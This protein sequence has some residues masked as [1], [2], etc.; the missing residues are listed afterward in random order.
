MTREAVVLCFLA[1]ANSIF[2]GDKLL[3]TPNPAPG[4]D[5]E[6]L[7]EMGMQRMQRPNL[8]L[9]NTDST[10]PGFAFDQ[11]HISVISG[12]VSKTSRGAR[13]E[14]DGQARRASQ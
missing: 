14:S 11:R 2:C 5:A 3:T 9:I 8:P 13:H 12:E 7:R 6:L 4:D 1:G 10:D